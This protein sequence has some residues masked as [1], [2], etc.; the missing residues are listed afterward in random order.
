M[1]NFSFIPTRVIYKL[2]EKPGT[3]S[4]ENSNSIEQEL[5]L[6]NRW[7]NWNSEVAFNSDVD[8]SMQ[9]LAQK[10]HDQDDV[11]S[12]NEYENIVKKSLGEHVKGE[13]VSNEIKISTLWQHLTQNGCDE[14]RVTNGRLGAYKDGKEITIS[15]LLKPEPCLLMHE[16]REVFE[17]SATE[18]KNQSLTARLEL[19][20]GAS[21][22]PPFIIS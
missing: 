16:A 5:A 21:N 19:I 11:F 6:K 20:A 15:G 12:P 14:L 10:L 1:K 2:A 3:Q 13:G 7:Q 4:A 8:T 22:L 18:I 9:E 17:S